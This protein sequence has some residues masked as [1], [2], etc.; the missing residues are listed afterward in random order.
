MSDTR[1]P[2]ARYRGHDYLA[3]NPTWDAA[4]SPWKAAL[5]MRLLARHG[6]RPASVVDVGCGAGAVLAQLRRALPD[7]KLTGYDL[8]PDAGR[9]WA[10]HSGSGISFFIGDFLTA[11]REVYDLALLLDVIEHLPD[12]FDFL[13]RVRARARQF[14]FHIPLDL[15]AVSVLRE[16]PLLH[17]RRKVGHLH[18][19]TKSLALELLAETGYEVVDWSFTG[20]SLSAPAR[21]F[22]TRLAALP[23][24]IAALLGRE[25]AARLLGGETLLVLARPAGHST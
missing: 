5:V 1:G 18:Y 2:D 25:R 9:F 13:A 22:R 20:A 19:F 24:R 23:R 11:T 12:P 7:A 21:T 15:S 17:V 4:D 3:A 10:S 14:V 6:L 8:A 16:T